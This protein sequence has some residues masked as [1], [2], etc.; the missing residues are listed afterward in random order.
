MRT[1]SIEGCDNKHEAK[2]FCNKHYL[3]VYLNGSL[4]LKTREKGSG[5]IGDRYHEVEVNGKHRK[6]HHLIVEKVTGVKVANGICVHHVDGNGFNN[7]HKNLVVCPN[8]EYHSLLHLREKALDACGDPS[9]RK[10]P[11]CKEYDSPDNMKLM[12]KNTFY[13]S[14]CASDRTS[15]NRKKRSFV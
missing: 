13:H 7:E 11:Y 6:M 10:C 9:K 12:N 15:F 1:C 2:G 5:Y 14:R 4:E 8:Q 3:R